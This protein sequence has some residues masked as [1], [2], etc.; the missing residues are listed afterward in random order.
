MHASHAFVS[1]DP[2]TQWTKVAP[3]Y[4]GGQCRD[5]MTRPLLGDRAHPQDEA[6]FL[7]VWTGCD[8][9]SLAG[10]LHRRAVAH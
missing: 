7:A 2:S 5:I 6:V 1:H 10:R 4:T 3:C 9:P 8:R